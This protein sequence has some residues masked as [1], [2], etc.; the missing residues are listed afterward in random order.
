MKSE[1]TAKLWQI[2]CNCFGDIN[3]QDVHFG[4]ISW[5]K[6]HAQAFVLLIS[7]VIF[8]SRF[9]SVCPSCLSIGNVLIRWGHIVTADVTVGRK[10]A[11]YELFYRVPSTFNH[12]GQPVINSKAFLRTSDFPSC[13]F[14]Y[15]EFKSTFTFSVGGN[16]LLAFWSFTEYSKNWT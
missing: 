4:G 11:L 12:C 2:I 7:S 15:F 14:E 16:L 5:E 13:S 1:G 6:W 10:P 3:I 8:H 9:V